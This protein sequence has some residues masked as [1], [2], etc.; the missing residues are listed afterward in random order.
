MANKK[1]LG[2][3]GATGYVGM[4]LLRLLVLHDQFEITRLVSQS[5]VGRRFSDVYPSFRGII[6]MELS[7]LDINDLA[8]ACEIVITALPHGIS[9]NIVPKL[10]D[11]GL[12]VL[13]HSGDFRY[14][15]AE[16]Y[17]TAYK[18]EH[19]KPELLDKAV[20][21]LPEI[22]REDLKTASL[23]ANPGCYPTCSI[24][25][26]MPLLKNKLIRSSGIVIDAYS[27]I[28]GAGRKA[29]LVFSFCESQDSIKP[30]A[31]TGHRHTSEIEQELTALNSDK[32]VIVTFTPHLAPF[33][34]GMLATIYADINEGV[35]EKQ[36]REMYC[37]QY[38]SEKFVRF[39]DSGNMPETRNVAY[40]NFADIAIAVDNRTQKV[41]IM[42]AIDN[43]GKG[44][45][46]QAL[47]TLN[48]MCGLPEITGLIAA[49]GSI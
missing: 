1:R 4:E 17:E 43:L 10:L 14:K 27:G 30:Y 9:S 44:A 41:K 46:G 32:E 13:D 36:I 47:Q 3:I 42:S 11:R 37:N 26:L 18:L 34:R 38:S 19:P 22:Y 20:Y 24:L 12:K 6:D 40:T 35:T 49:G 21:G 7:E 29:D 48:I 45:S 16:V 25:G 31:V 5:F 2:I 8:S 28:S 39:L 15:K 33:K 23:A